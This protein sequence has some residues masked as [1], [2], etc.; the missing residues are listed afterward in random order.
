[1]LIAN[2]VT[3]RALA[4]SAAAVLPRNPLILKIAA[5]V[6][7]QQPDH[8]DEIRAVLNRG[9]I[10]PQTAGRYLVERIVKHVPDVVARKYA[11]ATVLLPK[12]TRQLLENVVIPAVEEVEEDRE[13][14]RGSE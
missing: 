8:L 5:D 9:A 11:L 2:G 3:D 12:I 7:H 4:S 6:Y 1:M 14:K 13:T 10:D